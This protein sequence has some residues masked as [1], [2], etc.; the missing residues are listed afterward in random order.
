MRYF[1]LFFTLAALP[2]YVIG[3]VLFWLQRIPETLRVPQVCHQR[4]TRC[5]H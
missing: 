5:L 3:L 1:V 4:D 2:G